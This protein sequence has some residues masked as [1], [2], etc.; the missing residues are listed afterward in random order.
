MRCSDSREAELSR[1]LQQ[2]EE[3][4]RQAQARIALLEEKIDLLVR[5]LFGNSS[6]KLDPAQL[7]AATAQGQVI[8]EHYCR[9]RPHDGE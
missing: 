7:A 8:Y 1:Q 2:S 4:L 5:K 6:E 9:G 3:Q